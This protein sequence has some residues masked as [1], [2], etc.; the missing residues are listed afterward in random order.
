MDEKSVEWIEALLDTPQDT[1]KTI[2]KPVYETDA[3]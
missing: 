3:M 1:L 2:V